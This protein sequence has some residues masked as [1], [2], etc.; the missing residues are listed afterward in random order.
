M[1][2]VYELKAYLKTDETLRIEKT[3]QKRFYKQSGVD[4]YSNEA[5]R[6]LNLFYYLRL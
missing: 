5:I 4:N 3:P 1:R 6:R 2:S